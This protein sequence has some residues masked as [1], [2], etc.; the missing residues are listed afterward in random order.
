MKER[1]RTKETTEKE[2]ERMTANSTN[3]P[4]HLVVLLTAKS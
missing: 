4:R 1:R 2:R 3:D